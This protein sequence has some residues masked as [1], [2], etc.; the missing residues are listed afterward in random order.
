MANTRDIQAQMT[1]QKIIDCMYELI[2]TKEYNSIR[3]TDIAKKANVS[4]GT[5][6]LYFHSKADIA[7]T[8]VHERNEILTQNQ[9]VDTEAPVVEQFYRY[10]DSY[11]HLIQSDGF[12]FSRGIMLALL[13]EYGGHQATAIALQKNYIIDLISSGLS[14]GELSSDT[15]TPESFFRLFINSGNGTLIEWFYTKEENDLVTGMNN[16]KN[17]IQIYLK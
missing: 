17:L 2:R 5:V 1:R 16:I 15:V 7:T 13:E 6:Y 14:S 3:I 12:E 9:E 11:L 4:V 10:V 8:L